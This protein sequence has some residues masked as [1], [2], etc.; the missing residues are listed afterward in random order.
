VQTQPPAEPTSIS[1]RSD[2][3]GGSCLWMALGLVLI[4]AGVVLLVLWRRSGLEKS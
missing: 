1:T 3:C 4:L 2:L